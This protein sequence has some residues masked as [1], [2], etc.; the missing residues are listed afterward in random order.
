V[1]QRELDKDEAEKQ[2]EMLE[3]QFFE[4]DGF[5]NLRRKKGVEVELQTDLSGHEVDTS[6]NEIKKHKVMLEELQMK[7]KELMD[8]CRKHGIGD[9][10]DAIA[11]AMGIGEVVLGS[12]R[13]VFQRLYEDAV[14][15]ADR[16]EQMRSQLKVERASTIGLF[17]PEK[18]PTY[19]RLIQDEIPEDELPVMESLEQSPLARTGPMRRVCQ[20]RL[21][22]LSLGGDDE[23]SRTRT[24]PISPV[25]TGPP[26][27][28]PPP[29]RAEVPETAWRI[30]RVESTR[31]T[32]RSLA[33]AIS[34]ASPVRR[35]L[36]LDS[37][38]LL[39]APH[40]DFVAKVRI[41]EAGRALSGAP[42]A[43][44]EAPALETPGGLDGAVFVANLRLKAS[45]SLP[46]LPGSRVEKRMT[47]LAR[48]AQ[49]L[50]DVTGGDKSDQKLAK[51]ESRKSLRTLL[52]Q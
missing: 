21:A 3:S 2:K 5:G 42:P 17:N 33:G 29:V 26:P 48:E 10:V 49:R 6:R 4:D 7:F 39:N 46:N 20:A 45:T 40:E 11:N 31:E 30:T 43:R 24:P 27:P 8:L 14:E 37:S 35:E 16:L 41:K 23:L 51:G 47:L 9:E 22:E 44:K 15:R 36:S 34:L 28:P 50:D 52:L 19:R 38:S 32:G 13:A 1:L 25:R 12:R 18:S